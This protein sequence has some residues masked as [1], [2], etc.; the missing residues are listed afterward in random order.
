MGAF[1][2][3]PATPG[4]GDHGHGNL[5]SLMNWALGLG[6]D[7]H[8][9]QSSLSA[10]LD[11]SLVTGPSGDPSMPGGAGHD[12][13]HDTAGL[14]ASVDTLLEMV[15]GLPTPGNN[16]LTPHARQA[17]EPRTMYFDAW[18]GVLV[19]DTQSEANAP[20]IVD[21]HRPAP[22]LLMAS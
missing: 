21:D 5:D 4:D 15:A 22:V 12:V 13:G 19:Q 10:I 7:L 20:R 14:P 3:L 8:L 9:S 11:S 2:G 16:N 17:P 18:N 6:N 1:F